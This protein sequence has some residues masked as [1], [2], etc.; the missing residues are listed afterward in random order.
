MLCAEVTQA[1]QI[2][3][4]VLINGRRPGLDAPSHTSGHAS[5]GLVALRPGRARHVSPF[6][7]WR[8]PLKTLRGAARDEQLRL[9]GGGAGAGY[10]YG[11]LEIFLRG[12]WSNICDLDS[13]TPASGQVACRI[14]G[15]DGGGPLEFRQELSVRATNLVTSPRIAAVHHLV[16]TIQAQLSMSRCRAFMVCTVSSRAMC[17]RTATRGGIDNGTS[18]SFIVVKAAVG[19][20]RVAVQSGVSDG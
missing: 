16:T 17:Q 10:E 1:S 4:A 2:V 14:L 3:H 6:L 13:F 12:F 18:C 20:C 19:I 15:Y 7:V 8:T 11:R 5:A 9:M